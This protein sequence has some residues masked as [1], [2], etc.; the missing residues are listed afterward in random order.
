MA[1]LPG[2]ASPQRLLANAF[3]GHTEA[4]AQQKIDVL[5]R[6][7]SLESFPT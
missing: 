3:G 2:D 1:R 4:I 7:H 6:I 5:A